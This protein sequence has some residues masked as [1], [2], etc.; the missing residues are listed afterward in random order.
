MRRRSCGVIDSSDVNQEE[1]VPE[2][3]VSGTL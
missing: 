2:V 1:A 3:F